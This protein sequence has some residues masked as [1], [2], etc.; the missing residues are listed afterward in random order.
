M[1]DLVIV[2]KGA[3]GKGRTQLVEVI[4]TALEAQ[5]FKNVVVLPVRHADYH[6]GPTPFRE[7][8]ILLIESGGNHEQAL[9]GTSRPATVEPAS[10][11]PYPPRTERA[12]QFERQFAASVIPPS[13]LRHQWQILK[14]RLS[15]LS[16]YLL[17]RPRPRPEN[18]KV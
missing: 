5:E 1:S 4:R 15:L 12:A 13:P 16:S 14:V 18:F 17:G 11:A 3:D 9:G 7:Q 6:Q 2:V 10:E 8:E